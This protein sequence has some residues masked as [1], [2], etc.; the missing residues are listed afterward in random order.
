MLLGGRL[1]LWLERMIKARLAKVTGL[2]MITRLPS[3]IAKALE[4]E[5]PIGQLAVNLDGLSTAEQSTG[6]HGPV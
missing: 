5:K 4:R 1:L 6:L 2:R 3:D